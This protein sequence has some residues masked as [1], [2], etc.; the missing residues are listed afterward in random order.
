VLNV[1]HRPVFIS[2]KV[3]MIIRVVGVTF[4]WTHGGRDTTW[5]IRCQ[6]Y[7]ETRSPMW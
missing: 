3:C 1:T 7:I 2:Q 6:V 4:V 5:E